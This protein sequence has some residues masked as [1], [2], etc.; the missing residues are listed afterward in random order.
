MSTT[1]TIQSILDDAATQFGDPNK[2]TFGDTPLLAF[3][4]D[5]CEVM[6][7]NWK[8]L[9]VDADFSWVGL[10]TTG[11]TDRY[12]YPDDCVQAFKVQ[13]NPTGVSATVGPTDQRQ[14]T[15]VKEVNEQRYYELANGNKTDSD[16]KIY[17]WPRTGFFVAYPMPTVSL[18]LSGRISYWKLADRVLS[19]APSTM[20]EFPNALRTLV[21][22][23][24]IFSMQRSLGRLQE[25]TTNLRVWEG[26]M[27][28]VA[29]RMEDRVDDEREKY[30]PAALADRWQTT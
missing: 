30:E 23:R 12:S 29:P 18:F 4:N 11:G 15:E 9:E 24:M 26:E 7:R 6:S 16:T 8:L 21:R 28:A 17:Y 22:D 13:Y 1:I 14:W 5:A 25:F 3:Y 10:D 19:V 2:T 20:M 27:D